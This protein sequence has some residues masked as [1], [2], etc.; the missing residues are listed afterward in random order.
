MDL[1]AIY[2]VRMQLDKLKWETS[3]EHNF[4]IDLGFLKNRLHFTFDYYVKN[5]KDLL[6]K[7]VDV[8]LST[9][10]ATIKYFNSGRLQNK[11]WEF[12]TDV[13]L[14]QS[15][16]WRVSSYVNFS[17]NI[18]TIQELPITMTQENYSFGNGKYAVRIEEGRPYGSFYGYRYKG[19]Y[20][21]KEATY[22]RDKD[23]NIMNDVSGNPIVMK[24]GT[25]TAF[26]GDAKYEDINH[27]GVINEYDI[28]YLGNYMPIVTGGM[29]FNI[30]YKQL[31]LSTFFH[32][33]FGQ[34]IINR[35]RINNE[36]MYN[37]NNQSKA[38][39]RRWRN[40][41][42]DTDI[43]RALYQEGYNYLGSDRFVEDGSYVR[44]KSLSLNYQLPAHIS[45]RWG[46]SRMNFFI[47]GYDLFTWT[48]YTGQ[49][50]EVSI[51]SGGSKLAE[52]SASTPVSRRFS[53][54][55]NVN[56]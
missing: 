50:P 13:V 2:P 10:Y 26:P 28:V 5:T 45:Q 12:R 30:K 3:V 35:T 15:K 14:H 48:K 41:G 47:T 42:D 43:P 36:A 24:N 9:G 27:D 11:G 49:D 23:G 38:T 4:G 52:D 7:D 21:N 46:F 19:V 18:N 20:Q 53:C 51:P 16:D 40:E 6:Q 1:S 29:G 44:L 54:G 33:R 34:K 22:A 25:A 8:P 56:F 32:G 37:T 17:R 31:T 55:I 39:L